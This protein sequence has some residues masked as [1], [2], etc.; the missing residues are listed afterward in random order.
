MKTVCCAC[1]RA[2]GSV[3]W[4]E[5][6]VDHF[7]GITYGVCPDCYCIALEKIRANYATDRDCENML[8]ARRNESGGLGLAG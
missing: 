2:K 3:G 1:R 8:I 6:A 7:M 4:K 5:E